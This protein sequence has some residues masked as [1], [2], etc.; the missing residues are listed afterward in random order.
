M[1]SRQ[2]RMEQTTAPRW[3]ALTVAAFGL[4]LSGCPD[5]GV[6]C[7]EG[8]TECSGECVDLTSSTTDCGACGVACGPEQVCSQGSCQRCGEGL[9]NNDI[10][11]ACFNTGQVVGIQSGSDLKGPNR[12]LGERPQSVAAMQDVLLVLDAANK[13][14]QARLSDYAPLP[15]VPA[16]DTGVAPNQLLVED[17][18]VYVLNST[19]NTLLVFQRKTEPGPLTDG[20]RFPQG[21]GLTPVAS[22]DF[23]ANTNPFAMARIGSELWVT[24]Y[25]NLG[26]DVSAGGKVARVSL[27]N[28]AQPQL[29]TSYLQLPGG[30]ALQPFQG[31]S[32]IPSPSGIVAHKGR[33][34][35]A[36]NNLDPNTY[37]PG[38]PGLVARITPETREVTY[39]PLGND[40]LN[41]GWLA[42]VANKLLV[43]CAGK[44]TYDAS[45]NLVAV[46]KTSMV[47]LDEQDA[48]VSTQLIACP[49]TGGT[50]ALPSAGRFAV[51]G[52]RAYVGDNN[53][54]RIFVYDVSGSQLV[55][56]RG[57]GPSKPAPIPACQREAGFSLVSDVVAIP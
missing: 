32:P 55:E 19:S 56:V 49:P 26:G 42:P 6:E 48:V 39:L 40:C 54:G 28:P 5:E 20:T 22:V 29:D 43:S 24:L 57:L 8:L 50:C 16:L 4:L 11:A 25:G 45:F 9:C 7:G 23:G 12:P 47:L 52:S 33:L 2:M 13:L 14:R 18:Y 21:L 51:V 36:L 41:P 30:A 37:G 31:S 27:A 53:A 44:A 3:L 35:V 15:G 34:Y 10:V 17:P 46:E 1:S 38:G